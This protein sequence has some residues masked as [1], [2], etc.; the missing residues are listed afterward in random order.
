MRAYCNTCRKVKRVYRTVQGGDFDE[1][2]PYHVCAE[3]HVKNCLTLADAAE[4]SAAYWRG[5]AKKAE[6]AIDDSSYA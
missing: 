5:E 6:A 1:M 2:T 4:E 3:C